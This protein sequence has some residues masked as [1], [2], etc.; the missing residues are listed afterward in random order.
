MWVNKAVYQTLRDDYTKANTECAVLA[1]HNHAIEA[2][3]NW[4]TVRVTQLEME[5]AT[6]LQN[7]LGVTVPT[8]S[9]Q[10]AP[11]PSIR[12]QYDSVPHF[13]DM[14]DEEAKR[15][16]VEWNPETGE[17]VYSQQPE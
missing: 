2:T 9:I 14:G 7:Y 15:L 16:G 8:V 12:P 1:R 4:L 6:L 11:T 10:K 17:V 13:A 3:M 5:R